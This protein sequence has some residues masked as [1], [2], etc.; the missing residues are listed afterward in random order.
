[1]NM[2]INAIILCFIKPKDFKINES[3][4]K[5]AI[6]IA[7]I[8]I[9]KLNCIEPFVEKIFRKEAA[10]DWRMFWFTLGMKSLLFIKI[11][12]FAALTECATRL[13]VNSGSSLSKLLFPSYWKL[14]S[15]NKKYIRIR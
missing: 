5:V 13:K 15:K 1:M 14:S 3:I 7:A 12:R 2:Q 11:D 8:I 4:R 9:E 6:G 10:I